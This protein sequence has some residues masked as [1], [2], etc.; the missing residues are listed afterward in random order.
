[1]ALEH[2]E[3]FSLDGDFLGIKPRKEVHSL[4][5]WHRGVHGFLFDQ[6]GRILTQK[7]S[8]TCDTFPGAIDCSISEHLS[9]GETYREALLRG[10]KEELNLSNL[11]LTRLV[12]YKMQY[13]PTDNM[14]CE[15]YAGQINADE[16]RFDPSEVAAIKFEN[17]ELLHKQIL[18]EPKNFT[19]WFREQLLWYFKQ[20]HNLIVL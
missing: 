10:C 19:S 5:L 8:L 16:V 1:M 11:S 7:R 6:Q 3:Y 2:I 15:L 12:A 13:G 9:V 4:G 17:I 14:I 18:Q 20:S